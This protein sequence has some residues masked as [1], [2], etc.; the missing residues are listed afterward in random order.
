LLSGKTQTV[1]HPLEE[2]SM[3]TRKTKS[4]F[5]IAVVETD[6]VCTAKQASDLLEDL[7]KHYQGLAPAERNQLK[8]FISDLA[9]SG[10]I[11]HDK[12]VAISS[13]FPMRRTC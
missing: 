6:A 9:E 5:A 8:T 12:Q 7:R 11:A 3:P 13:V 10:L 4:S 2:E 1:A